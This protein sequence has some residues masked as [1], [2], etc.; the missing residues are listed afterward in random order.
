MD[1]HFYSLPCA[2]GDLNW[3]CPITEILSIEHLSSLQYLSFLPF[4]RFYL[5]AGTDGDSARRTNKGDGRVATPS[6]TLATPLPLEPRLPFAAPP[7]RALIVLLA[8]LTAFL[9]FR[10]PSLARRPRTTRRLPVPPREYNDDGSLTIRSNCAQLVYGELQPFHKCHQ[11]N[12][13]SKLCL[14]GTSMTMSQYLQDYYLYKY[15]FQYLDR[16]GV[17]VDVA[18]NHGVDLS[19][20]FFFDSCLAWRGVCVEPNPM[21]A[22]SLNSSL[23]SCAYVPA[24]VSDVPGTIAFIMAQGRGGVAATNKNAGDSS[25]MKRSGSYTVNMTCTTLQNVLNEQDEPVVD[26]L[27]LD[28]EGHELNVLKS[29]DWEKVDVKVITVESGAN[30][31]LIEAFLDSKRMHKLR[32]DTTGLPIKL[33]KD[34]LYIHDNVKWGKPK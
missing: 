28:V 12:S 33:G 14:D 25:A 17:Y 29:V 6:M 10:P 16:R 3:A 24:C 20:S 4:L 32:N 15:H 11:R 13:T 21:Y 19:N 23:R 5:D 30:D 34:D 8:L 27:S 2:S 31:T 1:Y 22:P 7:R 9:L 26:Y 18:A